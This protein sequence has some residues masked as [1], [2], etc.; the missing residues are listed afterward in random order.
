MLLGYLTVLTWLWLFTMAVLQQPRALLKYGIC[1]LSEK[2]PVDQGVRIFVIY[3]P[4]KCIH[5]SNLQLITIGFSIHS[6]DLTSAGV[7]YS[8]VCENV[9]TGKIF[10]ISTFFFFFQPNKFISLKENIRISV[11]QKSYAHPV[12]GEW[13]HLL[14]SAQIL[15]RKVTRIDIPSLWIISNRFLIHFK[16]SQTEM[17]VEFLDRIVSVGVVSYWMKEI[18]VAQMMLCFC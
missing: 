16:T 15:Q 14:S 4:C 2:T 7:H 3:L 18:D 12:L 17:T 5:L 1:R 6:S 9:N 13:I 8:S 10:K 11:C